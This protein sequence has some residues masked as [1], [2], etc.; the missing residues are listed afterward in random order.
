VKLHSTKFRLKRGYGTKIFGDSYR[1][2]E[3]EWVLGFLEIHR[4]ERPWEVDGKD[5]L[6]FRDC[7]DTLATPS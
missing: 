4:E 6:I 7:Y 1:Y 5:T 2:I 3:L